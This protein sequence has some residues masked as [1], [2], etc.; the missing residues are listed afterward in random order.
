MFNVPDKRVLSFLSIN[1]VLSDKNHALIN[2][3]SVN[4][5]LINTQCISLYEHLKILCENEIN[6]ILKEIK[7]LEK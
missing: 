1:K 6:T 3:Y 2:I 4:S 7:E 5:F